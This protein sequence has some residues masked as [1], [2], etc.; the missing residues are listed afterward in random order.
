MSIVRLEQNVLAPSYEPLKKFL[1]VVLLLLDMGS[2]VPMSP[3][4][5]LLGL[6]PHFLV[7]YVVLLPFFVKHHYSRLQLS[8]LPIP[9]EFVKTGRKGYDEVYLC[10]QIYTCPSSLA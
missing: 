9:I 8:R 2:N 6:L 4:I 7:I 5:S 3:P 1:F 10:P